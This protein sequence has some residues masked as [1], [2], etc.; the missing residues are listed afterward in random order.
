[1][2]HIPLLKAANQGPL[3]DRVVLVHDHELEEGGRRVLVVIIVRIVRSMN[4]I[5]GVRRRRRKRKRRGN[6]RGKEKDERGRRGR[7]MMG[8]LR[9]RFWV[10]EDGRVGRK[11]KSGGLG[12]FFRAMWSCISILGSASVC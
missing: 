10:L 7:G 1:M 8:L 11:R 5:D 6:G 2:G 12:E 3:Q 9:G 4:G